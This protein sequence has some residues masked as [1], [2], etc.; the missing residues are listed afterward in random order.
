MGVA[1]IAQAQGPPVSVVFADG[2]DAAFLGI[3]EQ[4][5]RLVAVYDLDAVRELLMGGGMSYDDA[6]EYIAHNITGSS[7]GACT[8]VFLQRMPLSQAKEMAAHSDER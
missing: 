3:G 8:P 4:F 2:L 6:R 7:V 5:N 1:A